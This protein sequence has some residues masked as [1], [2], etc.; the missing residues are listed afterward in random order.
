MNDLFTDDIDEAAR[1]GRGA[2]RNLTGRFEALTHHRADDGWEPQEQAVVRTQVLDDHPRKIIT[3]NQSPDVPFDRSINPYKGCEHGCVYCFARPTHTYL[4]LS[5]GLDFESRIFAKSNAAQLLEVE[6]RKPG[7]VPAT[8]AIGTNTDPYQPIEK[9]RQIMRQILEVLDAYNH[10]VA[11]VTKGALVSRDTDILGRMARRGLAK[12]ALSLTTL[13]SQLSR[14]LEPRASAPQVRLRAIGA[15]A[16]AGVPTG[17]MMAPIIPALNDH[18][19]EKVVES[20]AR[21]GA[22]WCAFVAL[23]LPREVSPLFRDWL[24]EHYPARAH[25]IMAQV[26]EMHGGKDYDSEWGKRM[27]G[28]GVYAN[29]IARRF[30]AAMKRHGLRRRTAPLDCSRFAPPAR[31]GDQFTLF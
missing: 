6:L 13:D 26:R 31:K 9:E 19:I 23:R 22:T 18:E 30:E 20:G 24:D 28:E 3:R 15:L 4:G 7:Y 29:L 5:A 8:I 14:R 2:V 11:I 27:K 10:P 12:V 17:F 21:A 1:R 25:R 16:R